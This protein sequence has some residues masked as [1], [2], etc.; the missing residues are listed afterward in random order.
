MKQSLI[1]MAEV[2][3]DTV[4]AVPVPERA[5][6]V[7]MGADGTP[8]SYIDR[9]AENAILD[10]V[11]ER[12]M[13]VNILSEEAGHVDRGF[14]DILVIDPV[15]GTY[16]CKRGIP[17]YS[18]SLAVGRDNLD[19]V[20]HGVILNIPTGD[21]FYAEKGGGAFLNHEAIRVSPANPEDLVINTYFGKIV[22]PVSFDIS[23]RF[24]KA[25]ALGA[26]SLDLAGVACGQFDAYY[27]KMAKG[28]QSIRI[29]DIAAAVLL[30]REAGGDAHH[31]DGRRLEMNLDLED[32]SDML[33]V[34]DPSIMELML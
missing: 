7:A 4:R 12:Q 15:D 16:N 21:V 25:R 32:R 34:S 8:T 33:A 27:L 9:V 28:Q 22:D 31:L 11:E 14:E 18:V 17:Y 3:S 23:R 5:R 24:R 26:A 6:E 13:P 19:G 1:D 20:I 30:L 10:F 29:T 2:V